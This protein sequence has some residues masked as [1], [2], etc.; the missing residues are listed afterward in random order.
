MVQTLLRAPRAAGGSCPYL[1][2]TC[3]LLGQKVRHGMPEVWLVLLVVGKFQMQADFH[4]KL[5]LFIYFDLYIFFLGAI[6]AKGG[7]EAL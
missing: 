2:G 4:K 3:H 5:G 7:H 1:P 6:V